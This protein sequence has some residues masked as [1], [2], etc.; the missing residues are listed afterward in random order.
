[1]FIF[2]IV[3]FGLLMNVYKFANWLGATTSIVVV[4]L[5]IELSPLLQ[6]FWFSVFITGFGDNNSSIANSTVTDFWDNTSG[7][8]IQVTNQVMR[9]TLLSCISL[10][11]VMTAVVGRVSLAQ[12]IKAVSLFQVFW[13]LNY[14]LL[15]YMLVIRNDQN[16]AA[17]FTPYFFDMFGTT[18]VYV[19]AAFFGIPLA[20][21]MRRQAFNT[22]HQRN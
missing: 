1:M 18:Y 8:N 22:N 10:L 5:S 19:F 12:M 4:A 2:T 20:C 17:T 13:N 9:T 14:F 6:K 7:N 16:E 15:I 3:G 21:F 11:T